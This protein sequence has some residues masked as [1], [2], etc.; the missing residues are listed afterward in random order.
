MIEITAV[1]NA[2]V[3]RSALHRVVA[4]LT[5]YPQWLDIVVA[6]EPEFEPVVN[7][8]PGVPA[9]VVELRGQLGPLRRSKRLR[10]VRTEL[11]A[12]RLRF[13]RQELD[14]R[15]HSPWV[16]SA[17]LAAGAD[18]S[19]TR[20]EMTL[21]Y[22]GSLWLGPL[23]RLLRDEIERSRPRLVALTRQIADSH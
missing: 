2:G 13:E 22:G 12:D 21:R 9:W 1:L 7:D 3:E 10:M 18:D 11:A 4:D 15:Q 5:T 19:T 14:G 20:L 16:L 23:D 17:V 6:A 8:I